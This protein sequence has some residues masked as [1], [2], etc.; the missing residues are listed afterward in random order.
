ME[1]RM[2]WKKKRD[3]EFQELS[4]IELY[5]FLIN[6]YCMFEALFEVLDNSSSLD[7]EENWQFRVRSFGEISI[8]ALAWIVLEGS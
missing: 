3:N 6:I 2:K 4:G 8:F 5:S 1:K 7:I